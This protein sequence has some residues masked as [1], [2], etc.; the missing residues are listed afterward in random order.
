MNRR[1]LQFFTIL[2]FL[3]YL[4][5]AA[6][7]QVGKIT[8]D[9]Q[10]DKPKKFENKTLK[11]ERT[12]QKKFTIP[13]RFVQNT[14]SHYNYFFNA[15]NK[16]NQVIERARLSNSDNF[17][18]LLPYYAYTL[19]STSSQKNELDSVILKSTA[20]ILLHD[21][22]SD[23]VD[24][25]YLLIGQAY[26]LRNDLDS[27][28]MTFQFVNYNLYP[29][30][31][32]SEDQLIVGTNRNAFDNEISIASKE[33][34]GLKDKIFSR[35]PS[36]NDA[37]IWQIRTWIE[38]G[39]YSDAAG[40]IN[41]L[42]NDKNLPAR[43]VPAFEEA[44]GYWFFKQQMYDSAISHIEKGL[45][46]AIDID[47]RARREYLL[48]QLYEQKN[49]QDTASDYYDRAIR[50]TTNPL[51]DIY[52]NLSQAKMLKS[53]DPGEIKG[54]INRLLGMAKKYKFE[55]YKDVVFYSAA[56]LAMEIPDTTAALFYYKKSNSLNTNNIPIKNKSFL[57]IAEISYRQKDY[58]NAY[59]YYD[60]LQTND[61]TL[62]N[63]SEIKDRKNA[64]AQIVRHLDIIAREDSLQMIARL[65]EKDRTDLVKKLSKKLKKDRGLTDEDADVNAD[66]FFTSGNL[67]EDIFSNNDVK[68]D[69]YFY[70]AA[71]KS[72]GFSDF[73]RVWGKRQNVDNWRRI[74]GNDFAN[75]PTQGRN[76][77][78]PSR[79]TN[80][81]RP[82]V[83]DDPMS[84]QLPSEGQIRSD[85]GPEN[86]DGNVNNSNDIN[87][88]E[89]VSVEGLL[90]NI[91]LTKPALD[92]SNSKIAYSLFQL[93]KNYQN[94]LE[95]YSAAIGSYETSLR[96]FPDSLHNGE[97]Y[98]NLSYCYRKLGDI[99]K[100]DQYKN[101]L[102]KNF[103]GS[104]YAAFILNPEKSNPAK[105]D[106]ATEKRYSDIYDLFIE[107]NFEKALQ[108]KK[109]SD[110]I[111][112]NSYWS[113]QLLYI[114]SVYYIRQRE[115]SIAIIKLND[116]MNEYPASPMAARAETTID[117]LKRR[118]SIESYLT[119]LTIERAKEDDELMVF[120]DT[121][122]E[123]KVQQ[124]TVSPITVKQKEIA[125]SDSVRLNPEKMMA[126][127]IK[128]ASF[129]FDAYSPQNV[130]M[131]MTK[132]DPVYVNEAKNA[133]TRYSRE[134]FYSSQLELV[135]DTLDKDR[136]LLVFS[137]FESAEIAMK[138][139][140]KIRK[141]APSE[142]SWLP[143]TKYE[144]YIISNNNL[145]LLKENKNLIN[146]ISL[147]NEKYPGK[148]K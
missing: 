137:Q 15:N 131:V 85:L 142:V 16:I 3:F 42:K 49:V 78:T 123:R 125:K 29:R 120:D 4:L 56:E 43:L 19:N 41:L 23:W 114:E 32:K 47:D 88:Q 18:N 107:G 124:K 64:L 6:N 21:L 98:M 122:I 97:L 86:P 69:W 45:P 27:A 53:K 54:A 12:G 143:A 11:S 10:K 126:A 102:L 67:Q 101:L 84:P 80:L 138:F 83:G 70:N 110:S 103:E 147:L 59:N 92:S 117:V 37:L 7:A 46:N 108:E 96:R 76:Q 2:L 17:V 91:P 22:R 58:R 77:P 145:Q 5:P 89:D 111:Y 112:G 8:F 39:E 31:K 118:K 115:D 93:G 50:H 94:L 40:L 144:F 33:N 134:K 26:F 75:T 129:T 95:D 81:K 90:V 148:F 100:A 128:Y 30:K 28:A 74:S 132:V 13:R 55:P 20:G 36:R 113:P 66:P 1:I 82:S 51:M 14:V 44:E 141:D 135:K 79:L 127:P 48:A 105:K 52:A 24:D 146:Y 34:R 57:A 72:K 139:L 109:M 130:V 116:L 136:N 104:K 119:N 25:L 9:L 60:S 62:V 99:A 38:M 61:T 140:E 73:K 71:L 65:S 63:I 121:K 35:P 133:F 68:G 87:A 106:S